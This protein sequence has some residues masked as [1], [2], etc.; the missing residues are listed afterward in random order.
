MDFE[1]Y[2]RAQFQTSEQ[3]IKVKPK[4]P[5]NRRFTAPHLS[6]A[7]SSSSATHQRSRFCP[8]SAPD[9]QSQVA[10][11]RENLSQQILHK[12]NL[13]AEIAKNVRCLQELS[14]NTNTSKSATMYYV[15]GECQGPRID[16]DLDFDQNLYSR[17]VDGLLKEDTDFYTS[18]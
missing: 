4:K 10:E 16:I 18:D 2:A 3:A 8:N 15:I 12:Q 5:K 17:L 1:G 13:D 9:R 7:N 6:S 14:Q 11:L